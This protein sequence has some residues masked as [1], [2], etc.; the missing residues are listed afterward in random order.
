MDKNL[1]IFGGPLVGVINHVKSA[2]CLE[3]TPGSFRGTRKETLAL[4][5]PF[6]GKASLITRR[7]PVFV[8]NTCL[9]PVLPKVRW[10]DACEVCD[11]PQI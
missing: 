2:V 11:L 10:N 7:K 8:S 3:S 5:L 1:F 4:E 6:F 9:L